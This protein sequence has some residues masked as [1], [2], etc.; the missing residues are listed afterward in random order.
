MKFYGGEIKASA[1]KRRVKVKH[2][3]KERT[4]TFRPGTLLASEN[5]IK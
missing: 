3:C 4:Y 5:K 2:I 1:E